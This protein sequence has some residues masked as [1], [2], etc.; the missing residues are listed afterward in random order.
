MGSIPR[1]APLHIRGVGFGSSDPSTTASTQLCCEADQVVTTIVACARKVA[2]HSIL[3]GILRSSHSIYSS[4]LDTLLVRYAHLLIFSSS[5]VLLVRYPPR[6]I[7]S[8]F[9][10]LLVRYPPRSRPLHKRGIAISGP[11]YQC[12][13]LH[14]S[15]L[16]AWKDCLACPQDIVQLEHLFRSCRSAHLFEPPSPVWVQLCIFVPLQYASCLYI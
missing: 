9:D 4:S 11:I 7:P 1:G 5:D 15:L 16:V 13:H 8:S 2:D 14:C 6:S 3:L 12:I 10:A